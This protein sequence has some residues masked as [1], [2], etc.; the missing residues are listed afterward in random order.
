MTLYKTRPDSSL[1]KTPE[2][3]SLSGFGGVSKL[4]RAGDGKLLAF[5]TVK[6]GTLPAHQ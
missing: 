3:G 5:P 4:G 1:D 6:S 2:P